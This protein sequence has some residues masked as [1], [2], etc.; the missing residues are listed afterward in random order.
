MKEEKRVTFFGFSEAK[1]EEEDYQNAYQSARLLAEKGFVIVNGAGPGIMRASSEGA[2]SVGGKTI[3]V[4]F[5]PKGMTNF[6]GRDPANPL[7]EVIVAPNYWERTLKLWQLGEAYVFFNGGTGTISEFGMA[8]GLARL[9]FGQHKPL[10]L[11]GSWWHDITES[12]GKNMR[13][14]P[15]ELQVYRIVDH[16]EEVKEEIIELI[17][18]PK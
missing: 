5:N 2:K 12:F 10:I 7:D 8:W 9:F 14:R 16:P 6:E 1:P 17:G 11:F 3:G 13:L 15:E 4:S 18:L